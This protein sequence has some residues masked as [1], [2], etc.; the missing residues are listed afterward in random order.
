MFNTAHVFMMDPCLDESGFD[1]ARQSEDFRR[2]VSEAFEECVSRG[3]GEERSFG[4]PE[5]SSSYPVSESSGQ[6]DDGW[7][8]E[9]EVHPLPPLLGNKVGD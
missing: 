2:W 6:C 8:G 3:S 7:S 4:L 9:D 1:H 5:E